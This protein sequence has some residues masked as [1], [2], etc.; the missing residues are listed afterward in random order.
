[1]QEFKKINTV[2]TQRASGHNSQGAWGGNV[3]VPAV[4]RLDEHEH[5][6]VDG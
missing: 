3:F 1:M 5:A 4:V 6:V 2:I